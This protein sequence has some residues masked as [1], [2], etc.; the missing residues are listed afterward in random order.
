MTL[1]FPNAP[2]DTAD[3]TFHTHL[4]GDGDGTSG[5]IL[6]AVHDIFTSGPEASLAHM[7]EA[8]EIQAAATNALAAGDL[9]TF[10][11]LSAR[12]EQ[13]MD[14]VVEHGLNAS[15]IEAAEGHVSLDP[16]SIVSDVV[17][18]VVEAVSDAFHG[19]DDP[20]SP[21]D[22]TDGLDPM[23]AHPHHHVHDGQD[24]AAIPGDLPPDAF[25]SPD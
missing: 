4:A 11:A 7:Q 20:P 18:H 2:N 15:K 16:G 17:E 14:A 25:M 1:P 6:D 10:H 22:Q 24:P 5:G 21:I 19:S 3:L 9:E 23:A 12:F 13:E 8:T